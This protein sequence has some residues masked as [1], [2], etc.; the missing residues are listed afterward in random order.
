MGSHLGRGFHKEANFARYTW[1]WPN[2]DGGP[3][4]VERMRIVEVKVRS[5]QSSNRG[6]A[7]LYSETRDMRELICAL[8]EAG[9][10]RLKG[11]NH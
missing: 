2:S 3:L 7:P 1:R 10:I 6:L 5:L 8:M 4:V 11:I 9:F